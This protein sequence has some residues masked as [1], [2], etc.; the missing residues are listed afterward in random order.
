[1]FLSGDE[2][3]QYLNEL[4]EEERVKTENSIKEFSKL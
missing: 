1:M 2:I 4:S 3:S